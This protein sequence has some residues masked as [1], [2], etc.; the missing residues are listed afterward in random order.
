MGHFFMPLAYNLQ[1][2]PAKR[3]QGQLLGG[4]SQTLLTH[5]KQGK[6]TKYTPLKL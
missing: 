1:N 2:P 6:L 4:M 5:K 3:K